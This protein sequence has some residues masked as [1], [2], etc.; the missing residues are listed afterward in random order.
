MSIRHFDALQIRECFPGAGA[1]ST[2]QRLPRVRNSNDT[3]RSRSLVL[4]APVLALGRGIVSEIMIYS[5]G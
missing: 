1:I 2:L 5:L 4:G 3:T